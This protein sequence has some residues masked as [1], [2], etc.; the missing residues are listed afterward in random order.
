MD[1]MQLN[2]EIRDQTGKGAARRL[3]SAGKLPAI[4]YGAKTDPIMLAMDSSELKKTLKGRAAENIIFD[5]TINGGKKNQSKKVMIKELQRDPVKRDYLH[6]DLFEISMAKELEVDIPLDLLNT[7]IGVEQGGILQHIRREVKAACLP[8]DLVDKIEV[9]VSGLDIG[10]S[11]HIRDISFPP[12]LRSLEDEDLT[13]VTVVA[14]TVTPEVEE[15][16]VEE[17]EEAE[18]EETEGEEVSSEEES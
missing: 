1:T 10:Q 7:P 8:Q 12:G 2:S 9:D 14:P 18:V 13:V 6:V 15:E 3:R 4:L 16:E 5:L 11:L 17:V